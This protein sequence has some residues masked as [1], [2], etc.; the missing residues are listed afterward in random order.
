MPPLKMSLQ[1]IMMGILRHILTLIAGFIV[2]KGLVTEDTAQGAVGL[3]IGLIGVFWSAQDKQQ[4]KAPAPNIPSQTPNIQ[5]PVPVPATEPINTPVQIKPPLPP[6]KPAEVTI[7]RDSGFELS[8]R[9]L[10]N[11]QGVHPKLVQCVELALSLSTMDFAVIE[12]LRTEARQ[13]EMIALGKSWVPRS[14]HQDGLAV[15]LMAVPADGSSEWDAP[16]YDLINAAMQEASGRLGIR[17]T[18][19][20]VWKQRDLVHFQIEGV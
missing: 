14:K 13:K 19:G 5:A 2:A 8:E 10:K 9:S 18:W 16:H 20:G 7:C 12:G 17:L 15:D 4:P 3:I 11:L 6:P 1:P